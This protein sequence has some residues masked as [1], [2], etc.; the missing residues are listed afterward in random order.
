MARR[1]NT[2]RRRKG[3][4]RT[5]VATQTV[6]RVNVGAKGGD[7]SAV[8]RRVFEAAEIVAQGVKEDAASYPSKKIPASVH[9]EQ[10]GQYA[11]TIY[12]DAPN[13]YVIET[14]G[15]HMLFGDPNYWYPMRQQRFLENGAVNRGDEAAMVLAMI[16]DDW[17][18]ADGF[19]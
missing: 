11:A 1:R 13:A 7:G 14:G 16:I 3:I 12:A 6:V 2:S 4:T 10:G 5:R 17:A 15:R 8:A 19:V 18:K 9:V